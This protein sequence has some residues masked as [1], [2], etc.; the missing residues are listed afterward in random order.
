MPQRVVIE[1]FKFDELSEEAKEKARDWWRVGG[2][3]YEWWDIMYE[4]F[5]QVAVMLGIEINS[6]NNSPT[7]F[8]SG[9]CSQGDGACFE[10]SYSY[11]RMAHRK[12]REYA[13]QDTDLHE[14]ADGLLELQK[15]NGY[16]I[17]AHMNQS[18]Y[19]SHSGCMQVEVRRDRYHHLDGVFTDDDEEEVV[20]LMR[21]FADWMYSMLEKEHDW[22]N[23]D[24]TVD[25]NITCNDYL[26][27]ADGSRSAYL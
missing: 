6:R 4:D 20:T 18:G 13:P 25:S 9:F 19:Y 24:Q 5:L 1:A 10:G 16:K 3:D 7:I 12:V 22:L 23:S 27:T 21:G 14:I 11:T 8:F 26:F 17:E 2:L 15:A